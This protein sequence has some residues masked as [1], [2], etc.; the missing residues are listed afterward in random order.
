MQAAEETVLVR[1][2]AQSLETPPE[3]IRQ[4]GD[5]VSHNSESLVSQWEVLIPEVASWHFCHTVS[6]SGPL[7]VND[8]LH[9]PDPKHNDEAD[10]VPGTP[11]PIGHSGCHHG[12][13]G[14]D[15]DSAIKYLWN[16]QWSVPQ[17]TFLKA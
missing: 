5:F 6:F 15:D 13:Q 8:S 3:P 7:T 16:R 17:A 4:A 11:G 1:P 10:G 12:C 2:A 9:P 14:Q